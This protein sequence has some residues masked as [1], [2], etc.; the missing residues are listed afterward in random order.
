MTITVN[1]TTLYYTKTG[2]GPSL[3][4]LHGNGEDHHIFDKLSKKLNQEFTI[5]AIDSRNHGQSQKTNDYTYQTMAEDIHQFI[6]ALKLKKANI[7]GFS[8]GAIIALILAMTH[9]EDIEKMALLGVNLK[10]EDFTQENY[11]HIA[12]QYEKTQ[13]PLLKLM[14]E[15]PNIELHQVKTVNTETFI[16][17]ADKDVFKP[18]MYINLAQAMPNARLKI[19]EGHEHDTY[20]VN[21][22][23]LYQD[24]ISFFK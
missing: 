19:M 12:E 7:I 5:Y 1:Q 4:L 9:G 22:D 24:F 15:Q 3:L 2:T 18:E 8:D 16:I 11:Q 13:E 10:P 14:L 17:G 20:I 23:L 6:Q 21:Q